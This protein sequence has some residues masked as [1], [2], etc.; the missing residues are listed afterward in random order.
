MDPELGVGAGLSLQ[1]LGGGD[2]G[3]TQEGEAPGTM[4][5]LHATFPRSGC[6]LQR[7][8]AQALACGFISA[9]G[10]HLG[11]TCFYFFLLNFT[12]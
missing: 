7:L 8:T 1:P 9:S 3:G 10:L 2:T 12:F 5:S 6:P 11:G 4:G